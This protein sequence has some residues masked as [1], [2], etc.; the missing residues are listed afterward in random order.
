MDIVLQSSDEYS[1]YLKITL[2]SLLK[3]NKE[4][5]NINVHILSDGIK[6][7][8]KQQIEVIAKQK[9]NCS[10]FFYDMEEYKE[11]LSGLAPKFHGSYATYY[12]LFLTRILPDNI[13]RVLYLDVDLIVLENLEELFALDMKGNYYM[14]VHSILNRP[15]KNVEIF[16]NGGVQLIDLDACRKNNVLLKFEREIQ[17]N[18]DLLLYADQSVIHKTIA[19]RIGTL[20]LRYN[21]VTPCMLLPY[22]RFLWINNLDSFYGREEYEAARAKPAIC[23]CTA[24]CVGRPWIVGSLSPYRDFYKKL[25]EELDIKE[26]ASTFRQRIRWKMNLFIYKRIPIKMLSK[27]LTIRRKNKNLGVIDSID[28]NNR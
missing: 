23:H 17:T 13:G 10:I 21:V 26:G 19:E 9:D 14:G 28:E 20:K 16:I 5:Q 2:L 12:K 1:K 4:V 15:S 7:Q 24:W 27:Y 22:E 18:G 3:S 6:K 11:Y 25:M 8:S